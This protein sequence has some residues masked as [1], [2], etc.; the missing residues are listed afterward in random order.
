MDSA[1]G[2]AH[3]SGGGDDG[4]GTPAITHTPEARRSPFEG[5]SH[6]RTRATQQLTRRY[7]D[8]VAR[9][10]A[11]WHL[12]RHFGHWGGDGGEHFHHLVDAWAA[13]PAD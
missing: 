3:G 6:G 12:S 8:S 5:A 13:G 4:A 10:L 2:G 1:P 9:K 11:G 7:R